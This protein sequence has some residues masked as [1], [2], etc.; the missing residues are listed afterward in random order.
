[1]V[2]FGSGSQTG[3]KASMRECELGKGVK[4]QDREENQARS[5][6][7]LFQTLSCAY[8]LWANPIFMHSFY[9]SVTCRQLKT[10]TFHGKAEI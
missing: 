6:F 2:S 1:M 5:P 3:T 9:P 8:P 4:K 7:Q 10:L